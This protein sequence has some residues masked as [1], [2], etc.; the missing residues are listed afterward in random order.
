MAMVKILTRIAIHVCCGK[1]MIDLLLVG[2][3]WLVK[4]GLLAPLRIL[5]FAHTCPGQPSTSC[6]SA[7]PGQVLSQAWT[8]ASTAGLPGGR[9]AIHCHLLGCHGDLTPVSRASFLIWTTHQSFFYSVW[10]RTKE[11]KWAILKWA[12]SSGFINLNVRRYGTCE[13]GVFQSRVTDYWKTS[14]SLWNWLD[15][16]KM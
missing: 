10:I 3:V 13:N 15:F 2:L 9:V 8:S 7:R 1:V 4:S 6:A 12:I 11:E 14:H 5:N 16:R